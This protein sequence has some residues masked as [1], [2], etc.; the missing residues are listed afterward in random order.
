MSASIQIAFDIYAHTP[1][2]QII[3]FLARYI[4]GIAIFTPSVLV[5]L[6][7]MSETEARRMNQNISVTLLSVWCS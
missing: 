2:N 4:V 1:L 5:F 6:Q 3:P 7:M